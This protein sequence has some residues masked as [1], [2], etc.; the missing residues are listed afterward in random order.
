MTAVYL[1]VKIDIYLYW[2]ELNFLYRSRKRKSARSMIGRAVVRQAE[3]TL[4]ARK[5]YLCSDNS[6]LSEAVCKNL[7]VTVLFGFSK[8]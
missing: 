7:N 1:Q 6:T 8:T 4:S 5:S 2:T 3:M